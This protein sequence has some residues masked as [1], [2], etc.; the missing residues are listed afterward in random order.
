MELRVLGCNGGLAPEARTTAFLIG[1]EQTSSSQPA[2]EA[3]FYLSVT[4]GET[5]CHEGQFVVL[6]AVVETGGQDANRPRRVH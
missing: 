5:P 1:R 6:F 3:I 2:F 4:H